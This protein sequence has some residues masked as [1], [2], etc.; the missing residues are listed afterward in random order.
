MANLESLKKEC[1]SIHTVCQDIGDWDKTR[2]EVE[3][4]PVMNGLVNNAGINTPQ[5]FFE[6]TEEKLDR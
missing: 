3:K 6:V 2:A 4:L 5:P 1:P